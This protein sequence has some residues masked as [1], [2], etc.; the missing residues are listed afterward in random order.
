METHNILILTY[1]SYRDHLIQ[2]YTLPYVRIIRKYV[3]EGSRL[4]LFTLEQ[5]AYAMTPEAVEQEKAMLK[6]ASIIW[7]PFAYRP[8]GAGMAFRWLFYLMKLLR[9]IRREKIQSLHAWCTPAGAMGYILSLLSGKELIL[10]SFEPHAEPMAESGTW[11]RK[12][13]AFKWLFALEKK[14]VQRATQVIGCVESMKSYAREKYQV[15]ISHFYVKPACIDITRFENP[16]PSFKALRQSLGLEDKIVAVYAG[17]FGGSYYSIESIQLLKYAFDFWGDRFRAMILTGHDPAI[18]ADW[19]QTYG[20]PAQAMIIRQ[21]PYEDVPAYLSAADFGL[22]PFMPVPSKRYG[23]PIKTGE[24]WAAGLPV[25][26]TPEISDD[27]EIITREKIGA[28]V[29]DFSNPDL[30]REGLQKIDKL[31]AG[32]RNALRGKIRLVANKYRSFVLA[33]DVYR[34]IYG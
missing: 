25:V 29:S 9:L 18:I 2:A 28:V 16:T 27:S 24:Y 4:Y 1:W 31:L 30:V 8:F 10:D 26:I 17:K 12:G 33:E 13:R 15:E 3:P 22:V 21:V 14:Q 32:D 11:N 20:L 7:M 19:A 34:E 23:T 5:P 6:K